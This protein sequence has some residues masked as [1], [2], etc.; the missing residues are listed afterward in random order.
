M[1]VQSQEETEKLYYTISEVSQLF[2]INASTIRFY[3]KEFNLKPTKN[4]K[5]NRL[6]TRKDIESLYKIVDLVKSKGYTLQG[7][8]EQLKKF[9]KSSQE[10]VKQQVIER[11]LNIKAQLLKIKDQL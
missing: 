4:K 3:E 2:D 5:G 1:S 7:A 8:K 6:F 9:D 10:E 11:L